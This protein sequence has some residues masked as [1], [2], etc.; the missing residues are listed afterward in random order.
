[1]KLD[2]SDRKILYELDRDSRQSNKQI[3]EK[4]GL[5]EQVVGNRIKRLIDNQI[6]DYFYVKINPTVI[7]YFHVKIFL[8]LHNITQEK[9]NQLFQELKNQPGI[10]WL[11]SLRGKYD[12]TVSIYIKNIAEFSAAYQ[13]LFSSWQDYILDRKILF[14]EKASTYNQSHLWPKQSHLETVYTKGSE[15]KMEL[16]ET[17][18]K[19]LRI[20]NLNGRKPLVEIAKQLGISADTVNYRI[21]HLEKAGLIIGFGIKINFQKMSNS[22]SIL[23]LKMQN[24]IPE[25][26]AKLET[27]SKFNP[28]V[29][30]LIKTLG[31][32]EIEIE[33][34][35]QDKEELDSAIKSLR[36]EFV[37]EIKDY[38]I[39]EVTEEARISYFP[40]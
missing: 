8:R 11:V 7:G 34:I 18:I 32:H 15:E 10:L 9:L 26:Y 24:M 30:T 28:Q 35:T 13:K 17:D 19:I 5:S 20:L 3:A 29:I 33:F 12:L 6:I 21:K 40:F 14:L 39:L 16:D 38:E 25:K 31:D 4:V 36:D 27:W 22:Y 1:M 23:C 37:T 2:L